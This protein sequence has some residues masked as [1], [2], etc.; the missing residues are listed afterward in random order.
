MSPITP[1]CFILLSLKVWF[2]N[3]IL[4]VCVVNFRDVRNELGRSRRGRIWRRSGRRPGT[5]PRQAIYFDSC[6]CHLC[7]IYSPFGTLLSYISWAHLV[8]PSHMLTPQACESPNFTPLTPLPF[9]WNGLLSW[10]CLKLNYLHTCLLKY[11]CYLDTLHT[12]LVVW[13]LSSC[14]L[15]L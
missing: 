12:L 8:I 9:L 4:I 6:C 10:T 7:V 2:L 13:W 15:T 14:H 5:R 3:C 11:V 1:A